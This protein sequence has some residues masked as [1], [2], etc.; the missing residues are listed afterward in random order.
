MKQITQI[1][2]GNI[3]LGNHGNYGFDVLTVSNIDNDYSLFGFIYNSGGFIWVD[4][5]FLNFKIY[6]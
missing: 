5:L 2:F 3:W 1:D 6:F 4:I